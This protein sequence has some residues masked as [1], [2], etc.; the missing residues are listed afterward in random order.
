MT[1]AAKVCVFFVDCYRIVLSPL[2]GAGKC[3]FYPTCSHYTAE[4]FERYG[5]FYGIQLAL[6]RILRCGPWSSGGY[7]PVPE[8]DELKR[9]IWIG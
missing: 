8:P 9:R 3:R 5:F 2:L 6:H 7:D 1:V 4:A